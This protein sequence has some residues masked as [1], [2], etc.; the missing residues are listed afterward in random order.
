LRR[1][2][3]C[4]PLWFRLA[5]RATPAFNMVS[6]ELDYLGRS[7]FAF[8]VDFLYGV[9]K[10]L[11]VLGFCDHPFRKACHYKPQV[12]GTMTQKHEE[13]CVAARTGYLSNYRRIVITHPTSAELISVRSKSSRV[14][15]ARVQT[16]LGPLDLRLLSFDRRPARAD[17]R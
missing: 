16:N 17:V 3:D 11:G 4:I 1:V 10:F 8:A 2:E 14:T 7:D 15:S 5:D 6:T 12:L 9:L 13:A